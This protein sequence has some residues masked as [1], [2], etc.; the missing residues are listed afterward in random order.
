MLLAC[1]AVVLGA[2]SDDYDD[3]EVWAELE[4]QKVRIA[5]LESWQT[6]VNTNIGSLQG[7]V[8]ALEGKDYV[9]SVT[10]ITGGVRITFQ[11]S[12][13]VTIMNGTDGEKGDKGETGAAG[14]SPTVAVAEFPAGSGV[15][16]WTL[17]GEFIEAGGAKVPVTGA[18]GEDGATGATPKVVIGTDEYWYISADGSATGDAPGTG[19][20]ATGIKA[21]GDDGAPGEAIFAADGIDNTN[22]DYVVFTLADGTTTITLPRYKGLGIVFGPEVV[23]DTYEMDRNEGVITFT[24]TGSPTAIGVASAVPDGWTATVDMAAGTLS[25]TSTLYDTPAEF[26][27]VATDGSGDSASYWITVVSGPDPGLFAFIT[28]PSFLAYCQQFDTNGDRTLTA[29]EAEAVT[30]ISLVNLGGTVASLAGIEYFTELIELYCHNNPGL[31]TLDLSGNTKLAHL[32]CN[33]NG[34]TGLDLS[35]NPGLM[36]LNCSNTGLTELD[37]SNNLELTQV[38]CSNN[39]LTSLDISNNPKLSVLICNNNPALAELHV[40]EGFD[41]SA[42]W[43]FVKDNHTV[44]VFPVSPGPTVYAAGS[45]NGEE[46]EEMNLLNIAW[47]DGVR[48]T[49]PDVDENSDIRSIAVS[50]DRLY[51]GGYYWNDPVNTP[52]YWTESGHTVLPLPDGS[53]YSERPSFAVSGSDVHTAA[54]ILVAGSYRATYWKN[55]VITSLH[56]DGA[57]GSF[58]SAIAVSGGNVY[59]GGFYYNPSIHTVSTPCYWADGKLTELDFPAGAN[60]LYIEDIAAA[61]GK[62]YTVGNYRFSGKSVYCYW[63]NAARHEL[64]APAGSQYFFATSIAAAGD[65]VYVAGSYSDS[66]D[67]TSACLWTNGTPA[68]LPVPANTFYSETRYI[69]VHDGKVWMAGYYWKEDGFYTCYWVDGTR[70]GDTP[71]AVQ[72]DYPYPEV[73]AMTLAW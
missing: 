36:T 34:M 24:T 8:A 49:F 39:Q 38:N 27:I 37:L 52:A 54:G 56:P 41:D 2:C 13:E 3:S 58:A 22:D 9:T 11:K 5:A 59:I 42:F 21:T 48:F 19:W 12:G 62:V 69:T 31:T 33:N 72:P 47:K 30:Q 46:W 14:A 40:G 20:T 66:N 6:T 60:G 17:N 18:D 28:D 51:G 50:D 25:V 23:D 67:T 70:G 35:N 26:L 53:T 71:M 57:T 43:A 44:L 4:K 1:A 63:I 32:T 65:N 68:A 16:Y 45:L 55:S 10:T 73:N 7:L 29:A 61:D 64:T 15:Y